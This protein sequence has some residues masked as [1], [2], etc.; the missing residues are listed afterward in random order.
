MSSFRAL[1]VRCHFGFDC[2]SLT[3]SAHALEQTLEF[4]RA[5]QAEFAGRFDSFAQDRSFTAPFT[6]PLH[7]PIVPT[8]DAHGDF[9]AQEILSF[10]REHARAHA[11]GAVGLEVSEA[12]TSAC[13]YDPVRG[14]WVI[15]NG[16]HVQIDGA[17]WTADRLVDDFEADYRA[18]R[19]QL[20]ANFQA[21]L[22]ALRAMPVV[23]FVHLPR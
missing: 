18:L 12:P 11:R 7:V 22:A 4:E 20:P 14:V 17:T 10:A 19:P 1:D 9:D 5:A 13:I 3:P 2:A 8:P 6:A 15:I 16:F 21:D 23:L